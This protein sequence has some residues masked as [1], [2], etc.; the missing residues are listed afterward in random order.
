M[1]ISKQ[2]LEF[3]E[4]ALEEGWRRPAGAPDGVEE[5]VLSG[6]L[7]ETHKSGTQTR[8]LRM[9]PG[10]FSTKPFVH[11][12]WEE[13]YVLSGDL[14]SGHDGTGAGGEAFGPNTHACRPPGTPHGPVISKTGCLLIEIH[15]YDPV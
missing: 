10:A 8:L 12:Y 3:Y 15:T 9:Q 1:T 6:S 11:D 7:D 2:H 14:V 13:V 4:V 5:K